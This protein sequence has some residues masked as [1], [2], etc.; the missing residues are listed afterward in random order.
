MNDFKRKELAV[1]IEKI[2]LNCVSSSNNYLANPEDIKR[3]I[4][5]SAT[6]IEHTLYEEYSDRGVP[7]VKSGPYIINLEPMIK[8]LV[9]D[10]RK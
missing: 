4:A 5:R 8:Q 6:K 3:L 2:I 1:Q 7:Q 9:S 10:L